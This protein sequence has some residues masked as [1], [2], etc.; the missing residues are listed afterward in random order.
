[1]LT[2][3]KVP[4]IVDPRFVQCL[5]IAALR[6]LLETEGRP[7]RIIVEIERLRCEALAVYE[8]E[9]AGR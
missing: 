5:R 2:A 7:T 3:D 6:M 9:C 8:D 1:M 4:M